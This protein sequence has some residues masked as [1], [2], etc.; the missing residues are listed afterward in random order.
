MRSCDHCQRVIKNSRIVSKSCA[1]RLIYL[2]STRRPPDIINE[3]WS[4]KPDRSL[5]IQIFYKLSDILYYFITDIIIVTYFLLIII[6]YFI[7][8]YY[9]LLFIIY[10]LFYY[11]FCDLNCV[12][13]VSRLLYA[14][15]H[16]L[17]GRCI[18]RCND[19]RCKIKKNHKIKISIVTVVIHSDVTK[20]FY[21]VAIAQQVWGT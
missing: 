16:S 11:L 2:Q 3:Y 18:P 20:N 19:E 12:R 1:D 9:L 8:C 21:L 4:M 10:L 15:R 17:N 6:Y 5:S 14:N 7:I 13:C